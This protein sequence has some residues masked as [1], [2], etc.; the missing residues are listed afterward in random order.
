MASD[1]DPG[2]RDALRHISGRADDLL[3]A[4]GRKSA[5]H[6][7]LDDRL[8]DLISIARDIRNSVAGVALWVFIIGVVVIFKACS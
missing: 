2:V 6:P 3:N 1:D 7:T 5:F 8:L 4:V